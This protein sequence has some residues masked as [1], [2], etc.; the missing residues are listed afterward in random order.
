M[1][2]IKKHILKDGYLHFFLNTFMLYFRI[3]MSNPLAF[4]DI[5]AVTMLE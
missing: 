2:T 4:S 3:A 1:F 5:I